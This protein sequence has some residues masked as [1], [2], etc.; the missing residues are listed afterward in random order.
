M[1][2]SVNNRLA[3]K[4]A[5]KKNLEISI[6]CVAQGV[7]QH[8]FSSE[9]A[10]TWFEEELEFWSSLPQLDGNLLIDHKNLGRVDISAAY[11]RFLQQIIQGLREG[12]GQ[13]VVDK[14][15]SEATKQRLILS[16]GVIGGGLKT[17][18]AE[19][20]PDAARAFVLSLSPAIAGASAITSSVS[21]GLSRA[22]VTLNPYMAGMTD[23]VAASQAQLDAADALKEAREASKR[24]DEF[25]KTRTDRMHAQED[26]F[27]NKLV[28]MA[29]SKHWRVVARRSSIVAYCALAAFILLLV[30]PSAFIVMN[31]DDVAGYVEHLAVI[32]GT[33]SLG[34]LVVVTI[35]ALAYAWLLRHVSRIFVSNLAVAN[36][37]DYRRVLAATFLGLIRIKQ[38]NIGDQERALVLNA[39]FRPAPPHS[40]DEGPPI[41]LL[42]M[43]KKP[44]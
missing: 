4:M 43:I 26:L 35:P 25:V 40:A 12:K 17:L 16:H 23:V 18:I 39:L 36:D 11:V 44:E 22:N 20:G 2:R 33:F 5:K 38:T 14:F 41:G 10:V 34:T 8:L 3:G 32:G 1:L 30:I 29:P 21:L 24:L 37:A 31:W 19:I 6:E 15:L 42:D 27:Y 28:L 13:P 9:Q 7:A